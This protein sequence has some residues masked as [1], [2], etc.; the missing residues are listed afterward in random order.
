MKKLFTYKLIIALFVIGFILPVANAQES[1]SSSTSFNQLVVTNEDASPEERLAKKTELTRNALG[2][3]VDKTM[4]IRKNLEEMELPEDSMEAQIRDSL[5]EEVA[6]YTTA[7]EEYLTRLSE[8]ETIEGVNALI[9][10]VI[11]FR[12]KVYAAGAKDAL[13]FILVFSYNPSV[14]ETAQQRLDSIKT[15]IEKLEGL[16]LVEPGQLNDFITD[17]DST[18]GEAKNLQAQA[19]ELLF[20]DHATSTE[21]AAEITAEITPQPVIT[22]RMLAEQSLEKVQALYQIFLRT[23]AYLEETLGIN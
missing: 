12:E 15:D 5:L 7:Y 18:L 2:K 23:G 13:E 10:E 4:E 16:E 1:T 6:R 11:T 19:K 22:A 21:E 14:L 20:A 3:A 8:K 9:D 17:A